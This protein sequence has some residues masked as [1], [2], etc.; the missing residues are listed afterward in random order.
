MSS[1]IL[2]MPTRNNISR[3]TAAIGQINQYI[4]TKWY[5]TVSMRVSVAKSV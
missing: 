5:P 2:R 1:V 4:G 3:A